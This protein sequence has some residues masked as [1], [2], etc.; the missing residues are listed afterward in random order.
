[1]NS[2]YYD[3]FK[4]ISQTWKNSLDFHFKKLIN[5]AFIRKDTKSAII[6]A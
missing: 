1:M 2:L 3:F 5:R 4:R 6:R